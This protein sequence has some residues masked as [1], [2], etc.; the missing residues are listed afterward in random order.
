MCITFTTC[1]VEKLEAIASHKVS[2][3]VLDECHTDK[4]HCGRLLVNGEE[5]HTHS[6]F[7]LP[8]LK[9]S[10]EKFDIS[11]S[12]ESITS[13]NIFLE[14]YSIYGYVCACIYA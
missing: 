10:I 13:I 8:S 14:W 12:I 1:I 6:L 3:H 2:V 5:N 4:K 9:V 11:S 7:P